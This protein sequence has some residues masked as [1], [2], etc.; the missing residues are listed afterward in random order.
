MIKFRSNISESQ[1][2]E[3]NLFTLNFSDQHLEKEFRK[4]NFNNSLIWLRI[5]VFT[6]IILYARFGFLD[7]RTSPDFE[8]EFY[9]IRFF[10][11]IPALFTFIGITYLNGFIK[12]WQ[13]LI[14]FTVI[15]AG[16]GIIY[17]L[18]RDP[19]NQYY[20]GGLFLI[21]MGA[22]FF[23]KLRFFIASISGLIL[24]AVYNISYF[25][26]PQSIDSS[27]EKLIVAD[28]FFISSNII[29]MIGLYGSQKY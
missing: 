20:Y 15:V 6:S 1:N 4:D 16:T 28:A 14:S 27:I 7:K 10:I 3:L 26:I 13:P 18:H 21:F 17:M 19:L 25:I 12:F 11:V 2:P 9:L 8:Q 23:I 29:C 5:A 24:V 22:Y